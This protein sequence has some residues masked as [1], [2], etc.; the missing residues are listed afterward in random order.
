M[1]SVIVVVL[2]IIHSITELLT[3]L[4]SY[5]IAYS[6]LLCSNTTLNDINLAITLKQF[7]ESV[8]LTAIFSCSWTPVHKSHSG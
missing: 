5:L 3:Y 6:L 2:L 4:S 7:T 8:Q 1:V